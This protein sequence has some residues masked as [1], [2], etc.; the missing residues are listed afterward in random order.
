MVSCQLLHSGM[1]MRREGRVEPP[2]LA[3]G[4]SGT[5][6]KGIQIIPAGPRVGNG[7]RVPKTW[8]GVWGGLVAKCEC[9][10]GFLATGL[11]KKKINCQWN[12]LVRTP[13]A[14]G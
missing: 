12:H 1:V 5:G 6:S 10:S 13:G 4:P 2:T 9:L 14:L 7:A 8:D 3:G 11:A